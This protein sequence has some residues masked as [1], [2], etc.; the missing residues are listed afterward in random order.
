MSLVIAVA[1]QK[2]GSG[3]TTIALNLAGAYCDDD[4]SLRV[5]VIDADS[6][7]S[8]MR[9]TSAGTVS[10]HCRQPGAAGSNLGREIK[11]HGGKL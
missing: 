1:N 7:N 4:P 10:V 6:Q 3:K 5:L 2:G 11:R 9:A 8:Y